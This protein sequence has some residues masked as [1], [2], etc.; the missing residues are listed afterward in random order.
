LHL[1][2]QLRPAL[3]FELILEMGFAQLAKTGGI[4]KPEDSAAALKEYPWIVEEY[5]PVGPRIT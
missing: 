4:I 3:H 1:R 5:R 2:T